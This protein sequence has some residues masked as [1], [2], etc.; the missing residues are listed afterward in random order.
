MRTSPIQNRNI[1]WRL[2]IIA[3]GGFVFLEFSGV[4]WIELHQLVRSLSLF[5]LTASVLGP[6]LA[7]AA[8]VL[9]ITNKYLPLATICAISSLLIFATPLVVFM[10]GSRL[11]LVLATP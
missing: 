11:Q 4:I 10:L 6:A 8:I 7:I 1:L 3:I 2:I 9:A 5:A